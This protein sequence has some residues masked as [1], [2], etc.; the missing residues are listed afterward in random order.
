M[1]INYQCLPQ[2]FILVLL[3]FYDNSS[4]K[5]SKHCTDWNVNVF[6]ILPEAKLSLAMM[7]EEKV[8]DGKNNNQ[9]ALKTGNDSR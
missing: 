1:K 5:S 2:E 9:D 8:K 6:E 3:D 4:P 7:M